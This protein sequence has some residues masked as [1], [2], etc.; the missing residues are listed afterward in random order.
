MRVGVPG[1]VCDAAV[2]GEWR[3]GPLE[4]S[5]EAPGVLGLGS[6]Q[7]GGMQVRGDLR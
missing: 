6:L 4:S 2:T 1:V 7:V 3:G 5:P